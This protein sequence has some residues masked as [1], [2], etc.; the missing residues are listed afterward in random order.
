MRNMWDLNFRMVLESFED[1]SLN[2]VTV[3]PWVQHL[4]PCLME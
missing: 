4:F 2:T 3:L 1:V